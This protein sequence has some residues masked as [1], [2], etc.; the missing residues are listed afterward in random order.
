MAKKFKAGRDTRITLDG[1]FE[2]FIQEKE[3]SGL[4]K[5]TVRNYKQSYEMFYKYSEFDGNTLIDDIDIRMIYK[6]TTHMRENEVRP[7]SINHYLRDLRTFFNW[8]AENERIQE[9]LKIKEVKAQDE[10]MKMYPDEDIPVLLAKPQPGDDYVTWRT[11]AILSMA[12]SLGIRASSLC[13]MTI[14]DIDF[15]GNEVWI[16]KQKNKHNSAVPLTPS[17]ANVLREFIKKWLNGEP[18]SAFLFQNQ[19]GDKLTVG[20]LDH[21]IVTYCRRRGIDSKGIHALRHNFSRD[22]IKNGGNPSQLQRYLNHSSVSMTSKYVKL[23]TQDLQQDA[24][25]LNPLDNLKKGSRRTSK[26]KKKN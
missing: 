18:G 14:D 23:F 13:N 15:S 25:A 21:A 17:L 16:M 12:Y 20:A 10:L 7:Q 24:E 4:S 22:F 26:F 3:A 1:A 9:P 19:N 6:W 11:W 5:S 2:E 8:C